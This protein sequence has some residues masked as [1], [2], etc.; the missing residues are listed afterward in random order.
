MVTKGTLE[1]LLAFRRERDWEQFHTPKN[2]AV[3]ISVEAGELLERFQWTV[4]GTEAGAS[5]ERLQ[6]VKHELA[7]VAIYLTYLANDLDVDIDACVQEKLAVN[8][9]KYPVNR[10]K[11]SASKYDRLTDA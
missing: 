10:S 3:A 9:L 1:A 7:D 6:A 2:L 5:A 8:R 11:G 4:D